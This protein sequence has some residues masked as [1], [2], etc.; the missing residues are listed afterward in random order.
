MDFSKPINAKAKRP[1]R[2]GRRVLLGLLGLLVLVMALVALAPTLLSTGAARRFVLG[3]VNAAIAPAT[4]EVGDWSFAWTRDQSLSDI[5]YTDARQGIDARVRKVGV[6][7]L[8]ELVPVGKITARVEVEA[9]VGVLRF[10]IV[11]VEK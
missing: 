6:S 9:P 2:W 10:R 11:S 3:K 1:K 5:R 7:S 4:L 8:W